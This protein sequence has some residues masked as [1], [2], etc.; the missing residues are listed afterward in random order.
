M[1]IGNNERMAHFCCF[2]LHFFQLLKAKL[3]KCKEVDKNAYLYLSTHFLLEP[4]LTSASIYIVC[5]K[6]EDLSLF[7]KC[8]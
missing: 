3:E 5:E 1:V 8:N 4:S 2:Q 7:V 6:Y